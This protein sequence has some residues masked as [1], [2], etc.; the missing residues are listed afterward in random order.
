[1]F[2]WVLLE[3]ESKVS[4]SGVSPSCLPRKWGQGD[5]ECNGGYLSKS[6][7][8]IHLCLEL[9]VAQVSTWRSS[10][11]PEKVFKAGSLLEDELHLRDG[12]DARLLEVLRLPNGVL[13]R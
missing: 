12:E 6:I 8:L 13:E 4:D 3:W 11:A 2:G 1:M 10:A 9:D 7:K 5:V